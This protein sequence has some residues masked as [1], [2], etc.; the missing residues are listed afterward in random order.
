MF[1]EFSSGYYFGRLYV[2]P[3]DG[4][5][6]V[7]QRDQHERVNEQLY[8]S[9]EGIERLDTPL[10]M[11]LDERHIPVHGDDGVPPDTLAIPAPLLDDVRIR[12]PPALKEVLLAKADR[13]QQLL[14]LTGTA[15]S[16]DAAAS[17][18]EWD[19]TAGT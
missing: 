4:D 15:P 19:P 7:I 18:S 6:A 11:K 1:E 14:R 5:R 8:A 12:N 16:D 2:E 10:V 9:G 17:G 13:A 3:F